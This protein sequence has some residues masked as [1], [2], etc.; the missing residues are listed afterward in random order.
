MGTVTTLLGLILGTTDADNADVNDVNYPGACAF[1]IGL[2]LI[3]VMTA[4]YMMW[5]DRKELH[6]LMATPA[7]GTAAKIRRLTQQRKEKKRFES[8]IHL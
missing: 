8:G 6:G 4:L 1:L 2:N 7:K 5:F 3:A